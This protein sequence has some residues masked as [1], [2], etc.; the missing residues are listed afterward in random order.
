MDDLTV[1]NYTQGAEHFAQEWLAQP[2]PTDMYALLGEYF[3][4]GG[5]T[6]DIGCGAG[7]DTAWLNE[8]GFPAVGYDPSHCTAILILIQIMISSMKL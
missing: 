6:A 4:P 5:A 8:N 2:A 3:V 1:S 7:R